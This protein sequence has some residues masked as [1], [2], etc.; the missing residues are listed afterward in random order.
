MDSR[1][2]RT[3][4]LIAAA[5]SAALLA[6]APAR[7]G[8]IT[9]NSIPQPPLAVGSA[10]GTTVQSPAYFVDDQ[11]T[12]LGIQ[13]SGGGDRASIGANFPLVTSLYGTDV[14]VSAIQSG[15]GG[16][17]TTQVE[18]GGW[19]AVRLVGAG[20]D[21][22]ATAGSVTVQVVNPSTVPL[23]LHAYGQQGQLTAATTTGNGVGQP[24][25]ELLTVSAPDISW[26]AVDYVGP[27]DLSSYEPWGV[28]GIRFTPSAPEPCGLVLA[29]VGIAA[30]AVGAIRR[31]R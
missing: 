15:R 21:A 8:L 14:W 19:V 23:A 10:D 20:Q 6:A 9:P 29:A 16:P 18:Y 25:V 31:R 13:F 24:G 26:F 30:G 5:V 3:L 17:W 7:A 12:G 4:R 1:I 11:Y 28:A 27:W 22:P 2:N